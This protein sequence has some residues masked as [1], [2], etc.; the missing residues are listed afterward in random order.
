M[1]LHPLS[2]GVATT[3]RA[4]VAVLC[5]VLVAACDTDRT[6]S[7]NTSSTPTQVPTTASAAL[8]ASG[9]G[10]FVIKSVDVQKNLIG[11][12]KFKINGPNLIGYVTDNDANDADPTFGKIYLQN[13]PV[14]SYNICEVVAPAGYALPDWDCHPSSL[15]SGETVG[16][17]A[18]VS[19]HLPYIQAGYVDR[20]GKYVGGGI[21]VV[22]DSIGTPIILVAD[23]GPLDVSKV[24]GFFSVLLPSAGKFSICAA[25]PPAGYAVSPRVN[26]C[27]D[28]TAENGNSYHIESITL[29][30]APSAVWDVRD[31]FAAP[32]GPSSFTISIPRQFVAINV[33]D[34]GL[35]DLDARVGFF[36]VKLPK[37]AVYTLCQTQAP[38]NRYLANPRCRTVD[39]TSGG[40]VDAGSFVN[41][42]KQVYS[43]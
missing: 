24:D 30:P 13:L 5:A 1:Q 26:P 19:E 2:V 16:V 9:L 25:T 22:K 41:Y 10:E 17:E 38:A 40:S 31:P 37:A 29:Y 6:V 42:E 15:N 35:N 4:S 23:N 12:A 36:L 43:P 8:T 18:F 34:N 39:V 7:P 14:G 21:M 3:R 33:V 28:V 27:L 32:I 20:I 11:G